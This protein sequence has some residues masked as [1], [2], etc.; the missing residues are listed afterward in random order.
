[1][2]EP[3]RYNWSSSIDGEI[4]VIL[5]RYDTIE[6]LLVEMRQCPIEDIKMS[7]HG[8]FDGDGK[9]YEYTYDQYYEAIERIGCYAFA[10]NKSEIH[11]WV[12]TEKAYPGDFLGMIA[13]E[14]GHLTRPFHRNEMKEE[15]KAERYGDTAAFA[16]QIYKDV[17]KEPAKEG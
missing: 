10:D 2:P 9:E 13:H 1:M 5:H 11:F 12:D 6:D 17:F 16:Y 4:A 15:I 14:K 8:G 7:Q 3:Y